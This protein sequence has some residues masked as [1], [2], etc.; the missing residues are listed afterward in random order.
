MALELVNSGPKMDW[1]MD[2]KIYDRY[3]Q[4]KYSVELIFSSAL[5]KATPAEKS[6]YI[7]LWMGPEA[8]PLIQKW[9]STG[10]ID[11]STPE[12]IPGAGGRARVPL[13]NGFIIQTF[14]DLLEEELKPKGNKLISILELL[15]DKS[16]QGSKPLN[17]WLS[18]VYSLVET[19][20]YGVSKDR[21]IR[22]ILFK[23][24]ASAKAKDTII[25]RGDQVS[26]ADV[27]EILQTEDA[28]SN[29]HET[30]KEI[31]STTRM[32]PVASVHYAS[33]EN[34]K[35][36]KKKHHSTEQN[37]PPNNSTKS[38]KSC[39]R[40]GKPYFQGHDA[41]CK[42]IGATCNECFKTGHFQIV[43]GSLGRLPK[44]V[45]KPNSTDRKAAHSISDAPAQAP[46]G[47]YNE[48]GTWVAEPPRPSPSIQAVHSLSVV[49]PVI[50]DIQDIQ[51][52]HPEANPETSLTQGMAESQISFRESKQTFSSSKK[53]VSSRT[54]SKLHT[55]SI[56]KQ[57]IRQNS[58]KSSSSSVLQVSKQS[59]GDQDI[60]N[61]TEVSVQSF[62]D[63]E[64]DP[65]TTS[66]ADAGDSKKF[67]VSNFRNNL[68]RKGEVMLSL[69]IDSTQFQQFCKELNDKE[70]FLC[71]DLLEKEIYGK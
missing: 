28:T 67:Q 36:S 21:I 1:T 45:Q 35:K 7:R 22:D 26:L 19:C 16:K 18:Y 62:R 10:K 44:R 52:I 69:P 46:V 66:N 65:E 47:F 64:T 31:D 11:F 29:T 39:L 43:C 50:Q 38:S 24:C 27:I 70:L 57:P 55:K 51:D 49:H 68:Q 32:D 54:G 12:E 6:S 20:E 3:L 13:S 56:E 15:S 8:M 14:W 5:S 4:W 17:D 33:Y 25:R 41:E 40:C 37:T 60:Q 9:T 30:I 59:Q 63:T 61:S 23:G 53:Q 48:Q 42:A 2:T 34:N 71:R 58:T